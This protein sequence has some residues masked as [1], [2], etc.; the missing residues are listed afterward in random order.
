MMNGTSTQ[1]IGI[2][3]HSGT[4]VGGSTTL[5]H[6]RPPPPSTRPGFSFRPLFP[7]IF[8]V[9]ILVVELIPEEFYS[10]ETFGVTPKPR[11]TIDHR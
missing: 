5:G 7:P 11:V 6:P 10:P 1:G 9:K 2:Y 8:N 3:S 4:L